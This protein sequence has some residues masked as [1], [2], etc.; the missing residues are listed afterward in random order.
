VREPDAM[1]RMALAWRAEGRRIG[2]VPTMGALHE[3]HLSLVRAARAEADRVVASVFVNPLQFG[4]GEDYG[5][6]PRDEGGDGAKLRAEGVD[7]LFMPT[8]EAMIPEE[9]R[10]R[11]RVRELTDG[12]C[13][14]FRPGHF[15]GVT[16]IVSML[17]LVVQPHVAFYG[18]KDYQ[19]WRVIE[20]MSRD[21]HM[22]VEVR[23]MPTVRELD[24]LAMSSR[25]AY[26]SAGE[27]RRATALYRGLCAAAARFEAGERDP[28]ALEA[29]ARAVVE[30]EVDR[31]DY[32]EVRGADRLEPLDRVEG[33]AVI[34]VA[35]HVG[36]ARLIDNLEL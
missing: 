5:A 11:V 18:R 36:K 9:S 25:N 19:Q 21:L 6:Y 8:R 7:V 4:L 28:R 26:L 30:P 3:G 35:A 10:T 23:G 13:G 1:Q 14:D 20:R 12:L 32:L 22:P 31:L 33:P 24:A 17:H 29:A 27:R 2:L 34:L 15:E 16:T